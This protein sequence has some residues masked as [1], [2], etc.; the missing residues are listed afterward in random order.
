MVAANEGQ[1]ADHGSAGRALVAGLGFGAGEPAP[2]ASPVRFPDGGAFRVEIPSVEG[3]G[4]LAAVLDEIEARGLLVH[5]VSQGSGVMMLSDNEITE[6]LD[7]CD[8]AQVELCLF[9]GPRASWDTG[10]GRYTSAGGL[11]TRA[12]GGDQLRY[13]VDDALRAVEL[14]VRSL[15]VGDEGVLWTLHRLRLAGSLPADTRFK[16]SALIGPANPASFALFEGI[17]ADSINV[18]GDLSL[19]QLASIRAAGRAAIDLYVESPDNLGGFVRHFEAP[20]LVRT[21]AP[22]YLKFGLRNAPDIYPVGEHLRDVAVRSGRERV[23][24]AELGM[25]LLDRHGLLAE[26]S[27]RGARDIGP[28]TRL[29]APE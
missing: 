28:L 1:P 16:V 2:P 29:P 3:P 27:P 18:P 7:M 24:R 22:V 21:V 25:A 20:E 8:R 5:R 15:L 10:A 9:L 4:P 23:R 11:G 19:A 12:R 6:M 14:G 17:G 26:A 13:C